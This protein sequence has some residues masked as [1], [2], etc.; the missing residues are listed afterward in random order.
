MFVT[1]EQQPQSLPKVDSPRLTPSLRREKKGL[2]LKLRDDGVGV[3]EI[4]KR[5]GLSY[6]T[7]NRT[8]KLN[9][10]EPPKRPG[11]KAGEWR[12]L[13]PDQEQALRTT[14]SG[15]SPETASRRGSIWTRDLV[16]KLIQA[17]FGLSLSRRAVDGY[18]ARWGVHIENTNVPPEARCTPT[19]RRWWEGPQASEVRKNAKK[20]GAA[21]LWLNK[22][23]QLALAEWQEPESPLSNKKLR[24]L[25]AESRVGTLYW[26]LV[27]GAVTSRIEKQFLGN[28]SR[29]LAR[30]LVLVKSSRSMY[31]EPEVLDYV[32]KTNGKITLLPAGG[33]TSVSPAT[34]RT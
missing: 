19:I 1:P 12:E 25:S 26:Q 9:A 15:G 3:M 7:V 10:V 8:L 34:G 2:A 11:R 27:W 24:L 30:E 14:I 21:I 28:L 5:T 31:H 16:S 23:I 22:P 20:H 32:R 33:S 18:L 17:H 6:G 29:Q 4:A 13:T